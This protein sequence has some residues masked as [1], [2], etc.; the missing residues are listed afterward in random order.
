MSR[1]QFERLKLMNNTQ[2]VIFIDED[3]LPILEMASNII[4]NGKLSNG[5][6]LFV[7]K[8]IRVLALLDDDDMIHMD[9]LVKDG[10]Y[11]SR[12]HYIRQAVKYFK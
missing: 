11:S 8:R 1:S 6:S 10:T 5:I 3:E 7:E 2:V 4:E 9:K 12:S